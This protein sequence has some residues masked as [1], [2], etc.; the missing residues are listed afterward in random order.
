[1]SPSLC[2]TTNTPLSV[3]KVLDIMR[4]IRPFEVSDNKASSLLA[5]TV[6][7]V[8][9]IVAARP[10]AL[11]PVVRVV[12]HLREDKGDDGYQKYDAA[13]DDLQ[14]ERSFVCGRLG[15]L[16]LSVPFLLVLSG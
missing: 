2:L 16:W 5:C 3:E 12:D 13:G 1:M 11:A 8:V 7:H 14:E 9:W 4:L 15:C 6:E 10:I